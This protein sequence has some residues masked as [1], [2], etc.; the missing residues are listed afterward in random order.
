MSGRVGRP[1][2][3]VIHLFHARFEYS[4]SR[5]EIN[6][7]VAF[8]TERGGVIT[9][10]PE[11]PEPTARKGRLMPQQPVLVLGEGGVV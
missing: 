4:L 8:P 2:R 11:G 9:A 10:T 7:L 5:A 1:C 6:C 3:F